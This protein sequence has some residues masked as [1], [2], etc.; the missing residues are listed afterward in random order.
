MELDL[1]VR[2]FFVVIS[3]LVLVG[4]SADAMSLHVPESREFDD[5]ANVRSKPGVISIPL[6]AVQSPYIR[7]PMIEKMEYDPVKDVTHV[8]SMKDGSY[9]LPGNHIKAGR[10]LRRDVHN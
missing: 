6:T 8:W 5:S 10:H 4:Q 3:L 2:S 7:G 9:D 1:S